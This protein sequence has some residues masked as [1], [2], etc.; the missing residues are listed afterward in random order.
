MIHQYNKKKNLDYIK[1]PAYSRVMNMR[2][3][4][5]NMTLVFILVII[6]FIS[7]KRR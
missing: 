7:C 5:D 6:I 2:Y 4:K 3:N 1:N